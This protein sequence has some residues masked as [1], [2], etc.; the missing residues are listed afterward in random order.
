MRQLLCVDH[1][2]KRKQACERSG[3]KHLRIPLLYKHGHI[4]VFTWPLLQ[5]PAAKLAY[6]SIAV[7]SGVRHSNR[8]CLMPSPE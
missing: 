2:G 6:F 5:C 7:F 4:S 1:S 3:R 8:K